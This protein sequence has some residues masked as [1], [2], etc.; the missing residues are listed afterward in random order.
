MKVNRIEIGSSNPGLS[1]LALMTGG[2]AFMNAE[3]VRKMDSSPKGPPL[4]YCV[5]FPVL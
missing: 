2:K 4:H 3:K 1:S 5:L